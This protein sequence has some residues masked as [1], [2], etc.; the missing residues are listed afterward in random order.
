MYSQY[1]ISIT[2]SKTEQEE[3]ERPAG[4]AEVKFQLERIKNSPICCLGI[5]VAQQK[6]RL[7]L[8]G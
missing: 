7:I 5:N 2:S 6:I 1:L 3:T 8:E 4:K